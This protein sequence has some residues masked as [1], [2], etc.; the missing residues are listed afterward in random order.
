[1]GKC[2]A[3]CKVFGNIN[4]GEDEIYHHKDCPN[5][6]ESMSERLNNAESRIINIK[7][8]AK[9]LIYKEK[10]EVISKNECWICMY[11]EHMYEHD[12]FKGL[13]NLINTEWKN[14]R[15]LVG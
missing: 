12:T 2:I 8:E 15:H 6:P 5:Y 9:F 7:D 11:N 4:S 13:I 3:G 1:M 14:D 10:A